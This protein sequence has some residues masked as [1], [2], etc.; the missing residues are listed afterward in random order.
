VRLIVLIPLLLVGAAVC[1]AQTAEEKRIPPSCKS[2]RQES[3]A[4]P[5][6][7]F[8]F[9][10]NESLKGHPLVKFQIN[11]DG[12]V[13]N[14]RL[15]HGCGVRDINKKVVESVS[16]W[17]YKPKPECGVVDVELMVIIDLH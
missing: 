12:T 7:P 14:V 16:K 15:V 3:A 2:D 1:P 4:L 17:K 8:K 10:P 9:L 6:G 5:T 13:S 11:E